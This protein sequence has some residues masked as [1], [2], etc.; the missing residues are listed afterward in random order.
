MNQ[1]GR[2]RIPFLFAIDFDE[3]QP[4]IEPLEEV[5]P[6][7]ILYDINGKTN[8]PD[9]YPALPD[10]VSF[11]KKPVSLQTYTKSFKRVM[12]HLLAGNSFLVNLTMPTR[13]YTN[14]S[15]KQIF[16]YS[17]ALYKLWYQD[18]FV[19]FSPEIFVRIEKGVIS[20]HPMKGTI[21][22]TVPGA[23]KKLLHNPKE[24]A[25]HVT[26]V[27]LIRNDLSM[28]ASDV[29][30]EKFRYLDRIITH[31]KE[32]LQASS[33]ITGTM[34]PDYH[35][36]IGDIIAA[37]LPAGSVSGAPKSKTLEI[38]REAE[39]Y[40]RGYYTGV[41]GIFDGENVDCGVMIRFIEQEEGGLVFKS[42]GGITAQSDLSDEYDEL[43]DKVYVPINRIC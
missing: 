40:K 42:G 18:K 36:R 5:D 13:I 37:L 41:V 25:E 28:V 35:T 6:E 7:E 39:S 12:Q 22:S 16:F 4:L 20:S 1:L 10:V 26:I 23:E 24:L 3:R 11:E 9:F 2:E 21:D 33:Q 30:V 43:I 32:L 8:T 38:I 19:V 14:L 27:D 15:L 31:D 29:R 17:Q 34:P